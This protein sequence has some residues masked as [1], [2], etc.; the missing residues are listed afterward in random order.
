MKNTRIH[1]PREIYEYYVNNYPI[2]E[3]LKL[4]SGNY[5]KKYLKY[6]TK[7][8]KLKNQLNIK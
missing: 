7:Y 6:K 5:N 3:S 1:L 2:Y 8:L 4:D